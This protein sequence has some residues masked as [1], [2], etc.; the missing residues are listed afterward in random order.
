MFMVYPANKQ[1][2]SKPFL[3]GNSKKYVAM[4]PLPFF[5]IVIAGLDFSFR[6]TGTKKEGITF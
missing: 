4:F 6:A 5:V 3:D 2:N 1:T